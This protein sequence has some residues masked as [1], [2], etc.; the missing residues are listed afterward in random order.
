MTLT[1]SEVTSLTQTIDIWE[2][3]EYTCTALVA[4]A[5][6]GEYIADF[7]EWWRRDRRFWKWFGPIEHRKDAVAKFSTLVLIG[8]LAGELLCV[9]VTNQ[10]SGKLVGTLGDRAQEAFAKSD[11]ALN[12]ARSAV[13]QANSAM[14]QSK[15]ASQQ[16]DEANKSASSAVEVARAA[17]KEAD[18]F[19][20]DIISAKKQATEAESHLAE[21]L[22]RAADASAQLQRINTPRFIAD[23]SGLVEA[24]KA[25]AG[26]R[27]AF[28][29]VYPDH[30]SFQ[31]LMQIDD[32]LTRAGW[33][34]VKQTNTVLNIPAFQ[35]SGREDVVNSG[36]M[37]TGVRIEV[38]STETRET[39]LSSANKVPPHL[40]VAI[41][42]KE[43]FFK[44]ISPPEKT[45]PDNG[46]ALIPGS[47]TV[48]SISVGKKP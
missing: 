19:E 4:V 23:A 15:A 14:G 44:H 38:N 5:C 16:S 25:Y 45:T 35:I 30:E 43:L 41:F 48:I 22:T 40:R 9:V 39:L 33:N 28:A 34:R 12:N 27:F 29:S 37:T 26:T 47:S 11:I 42:L 31:L 20:E 21:A 13:A 3:A 6:F 36:P 17:H 18:S 1:A 46:V 7:T 8:A 24:L 2:F 32:V 10:L